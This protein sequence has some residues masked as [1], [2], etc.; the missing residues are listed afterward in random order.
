MFLW[1]LLSEG[2]RDLILKAESGERAVK[3][4]S[5]LSQ[6]LVE[7]ID[8]SCKLTYFSFSLQNKSFHGYIYFKSRKTHDFCFEKRISSPTFVILQFDKMHNSRRRF[9]SRFAS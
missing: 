8:K 2:F 7:T 9:G 3:A 4:F 6:H 5:L 1:F